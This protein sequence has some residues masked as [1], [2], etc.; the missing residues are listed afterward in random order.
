MY[1]P[2]SNSQYFSNNYF[3]NLRML[4]DFFHNKQLVILG[5]LNSRTSTPLFASRHE[6]YT[7]NPDTVI[8]DC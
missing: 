1:I 6:W 8:N 4:Y 3:N 2:P 7:E 5:D